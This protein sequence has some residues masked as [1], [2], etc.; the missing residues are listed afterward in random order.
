M[1]TPEAQAIYRRRKRIAE[2]PNLWIK[3]KLGCAG[4]GYAGCPRCDVKRS[5]FATYNI[6]QW[7]RLRWKPGLQA[8][9]IA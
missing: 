2:F 1:K 6:Q 9:A 4:F 8:A 5:G 3:E 7:I